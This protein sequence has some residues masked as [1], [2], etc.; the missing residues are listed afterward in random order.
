MLQ[1]SAKQARTSRSCSITCESE[2]LG[3][4][5]LLEG[6]YLLDNVM[7]ALALENLKRL[8]NCWPLVLHCLRLTS[9][10]SS[11]RTV[12]QQLQMSTLALRI[13]FVSAGMLSAGKSQ[14]ASGREVQWPL[15]HFQLAVQGHIRLPRIRGRNGMAAS[16]NGDVVTS[17]RNAVANT[18]YVAWK[19]AKCVPQEPVAMATCRSMYARCHELTALG[20]LESEVEIL[21]AYFGASPHFCCRQTVHSE[22]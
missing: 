7:L 15:A 10:H 21:D 4:Q 3:E 14:G 5:S 6:I 22:C 19:L 11:L 9:A 18:S 8:R 13:A 16:A 17:A 1:Y 2:G 12:R 20:R